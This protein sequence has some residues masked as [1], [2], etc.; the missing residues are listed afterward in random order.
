[1][2]AV[3]LLGR[4]LTVVLLLGRFLTA[5]VTLGRACRGR[6]NEVQVIRRHHVR[7]DR[8]ISSVNIRVVPCRGCP[9]PRG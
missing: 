2:T 4:V 7:Q 8:D 6:V 9:C 1:M 3:L 5:R